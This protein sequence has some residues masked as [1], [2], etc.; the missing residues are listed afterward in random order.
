LSV[1]FVALLSGLLTAVSYRW[2][3]SWCAATLTPYVWSLVR[4]NPAS[5]LAAGLPFL[6]RLH[7]FSSPA[8][9]AMIPL[10]RLALLLMVPLHHGLRLLHSAVSVPARSVQRTREL[11]FERYNPLTKIWPE[12]D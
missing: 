3:S 4:G 8:A 6:V 12:E 2:G 7:V 5:A 10:T 11:A 9:L 1:S